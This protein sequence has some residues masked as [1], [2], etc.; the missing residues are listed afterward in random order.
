MVDELKSHLYERVLK[1]KNALV[2]YQLAMGIFAVV[3]IQIIEA[4]S[5]LA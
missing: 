4:D 1:E 2:C 3:R 5:F